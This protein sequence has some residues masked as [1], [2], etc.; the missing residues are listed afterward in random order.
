MYFDLI[1]LRNLRINII[2]ISINMAEIEITNTP[3][4]Y[5]IRLLT[6]YRQYGVLNHVPFVI[7][8]I[9]PGKVN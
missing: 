2:D 7:Q 3:V 5:D 9:L 1:Y 4:Q 8:P 6:E